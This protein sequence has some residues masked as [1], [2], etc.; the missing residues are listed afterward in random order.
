MIEVLAI[1]RST[2]KMN[3]CEVPVVFNIIVYVMVGSII[4]MDLISSSTTPVSVAT[5]IIS[6]GTI[7][8][9]RSS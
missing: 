7:S 6:N 1:I 4:I 3:T 9:I 2:I 5:S 8:V